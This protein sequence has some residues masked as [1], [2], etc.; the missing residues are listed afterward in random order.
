M[1]FDDPSADL[2]LVLRRFARAVVVITSLHAGKR[3]AMA[4]TAVS[5]VSLDPPM[6]L[7]C[8]NR[9]ASIHE[10]LAAGA[11]FCLNILR[12]C[13][14]D[15][16]ANCSGKVKGDERFAVGEWGYAKGRLILAGA[17]A[18]IICR[19]A[20]RIEAGSHSIFIG[21]VEHARESGEVDPLIYVD[22]SYAV[23]SSNRLGSFGL[24]S[25]LDSL[26]DDRAG[27]SGPCT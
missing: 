3:Y 6:M 2:R 15:I 20:R 5:E 23:A 8:I 14:S 12:S 25:R 11:D 1:E 22:G 7:V 16:S 24:S 18:N 10:P 13:Q 21:E 26:A 27:R 17:Q 4:A 19:N 9:S